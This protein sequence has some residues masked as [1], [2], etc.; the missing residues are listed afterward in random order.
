MDISIHRV[1]YIILQ[2]Q[3]QMQIAFFLWKAF[4]PIRPVGNIPPSFC[5]FAYNSSIKSSTPLKPCD[6][7]YF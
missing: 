6:N 1:N 4:N 7:Y 3:M 5:F 2:M